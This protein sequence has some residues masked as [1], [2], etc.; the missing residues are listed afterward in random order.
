MKRLFPPL[1]HAVVSLLQVGATADKSYR[2]NV[3]YLQF[4]PYFS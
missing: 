3:C 1:V 4:N 2:P